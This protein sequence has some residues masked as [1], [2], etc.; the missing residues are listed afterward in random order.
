MHILLSGWL[1]CAGCAFRDAVQRAFDQWRPKGN[2]PQA[3]AIDLVWTYLA[4][5]AY[6][7][8][9]PLVAALD[10]EDDSRRYV[11]DWDVLIETPDGANISAVM[12]RPKDDSKPLP[13]LLEF[14][15][16]VDVAHLR[17]GVRGSR[18]CGNRGLHAR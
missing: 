3:D 8:F 10:E 6:R 16:Y 5:D 11:T 15:I 4:F 13:T 12:V 1:E 18:L 14:T 17:Q 2:I 9:H 7:N